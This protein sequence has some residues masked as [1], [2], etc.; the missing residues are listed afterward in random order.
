MVFDLAPF[1]Y[2][3]LL[4][5]SVVL[6]LLV[7]AWAQVNVLQPEC[8]S[9]EAEEAALVARDYINAQHNRG[10]KYDLN[11]IEDI[12]VYTTPMG[13]STYVL[14]I[15]LLETECHVLDPTP[16]ANCTVRPKVLTAI[17]GDCDVVLKKVGGALA[18][19][20]FKC[21]TEGS[22]E[23]LCVGCPTLLPLNQTDAVD[24]VHA[25]LVTVNNITVNATYV[26]HEIG[27]MSTQVVSG[28]A[29]FLAEYVIVEANCTDG[30]CLPLQGAMATR[31]IC[32]AKG[33]PA[34]HT[35]DCR[36]FAFQMTSGNNTAT[37]H[38]AVLPVVHEPRQPRN[39]SQTSL[40]FHKLPTI[41]NPERNTY[42]SDESEEDSEEVVP[43][44]PAAAGT[45]ALPA[46]DADLHLPDASPP[47]AAA[48]LQNATA[49]LPDDAHPPV[50]APLA[51]D[52]SSSA[53][54]DPRSKEHP[55]M[56]KRDLVAASAAA[57]PVDQ[58]VLKPICP[59]RV[60]LF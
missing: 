13:E 21:K 2:M 48:P 5:F 47:D 33:V 49:P 42:L 34:D 8:D 53:S 27:R 38:P 16:L 15:E 19:T 36:M 39:G 52:D 37:A 11:R 30:L 10:Y 3:N 43:V 28:G 56:F 4:G 32:Y 44:D 7:G 51:T 23:D 40:G 1:S 9:P 59:G 45:P 12:K 6:V 57:S 41:H 55:P 54:D 18:V 22:T 25:S 20:A 14:E 31:G 35:V 50:A 58:I 29:I 24:F 26:L 17:E 46:P 60:R